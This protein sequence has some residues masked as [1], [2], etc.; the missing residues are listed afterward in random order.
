MITVSRSEP[1]PAAFRAARAIVFGEDPESREEI[2]HA[3][4]RVIDTQ[5]GLPELLAALVECFDAAIPQAQAFP[6]D[7]AAKAAY[8]AKVLPNHLRGLNRLARHKAEREAELLAALEACEVAMAAEAEQ[9]AEA[10]MG[11][12]FEDMN[13]PLGQARAALAKAKKSDYPVDVS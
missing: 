7:I 5:T 11:Q 12:Y 3:V 1:T 2:V 10:G 9:R 4:A 8:A 13:R 6:G